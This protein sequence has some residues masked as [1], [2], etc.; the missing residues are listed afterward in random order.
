MIYPTDIEALGVVRNCFMA[1]EWRN[2]VCAHHSLH[3]FDFIEHVRNRLTKLLFSEPTLS[4]S[5]WHEFNVAKD[6]NY[7]LDILC[8]SELWWRIPWDPSPQELLLSNPIVFLPEESIIY[9]L[10]RSLVNQI[11]EANPDWLP[12]KNWAKDQDLILSRV[13][14]VE[15]LLWGIYDD[16]FFELEELEKRKVLL[17]EL[18]EKGPA[19]KAKTFKYQD[20]LS[21]KFRIKKR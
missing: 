8:R 14:A 17:S 5:L 6:L 12:F 2:R 20:L 19:E 16:L 1:F 3:K 18:L 21:T 11:L 9:R 15:E 4:R 10:F 7:W 13:W